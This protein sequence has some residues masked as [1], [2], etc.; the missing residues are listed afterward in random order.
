MERIDIVRR[1]LE[2][3]LRCRR[4]LRP[5]F[6]TVLIPQSSL[7][8]ASEVGVS[9]YKAG[10]NNFTAAIDHLIGF[11]RVHNSDTR[12][13]TVLN[14]HMRVVENL[15]ASIHRDDGRVFKESLHRKIV[16]VGLTPAN[17]A[18]SGRTV[19]RRFPVSFRH[20]AT[21][22]SFF[23]G[24]QSSRASLSSLSLPRASTRLSCEPCR[25]LP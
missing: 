22:R 14:Q 5:G 3:F 11:A 4:F 25:W 18:G 17:A 13:P 16:S 6:E 19:S 7:K 21:L 20:R 9:A 2:R 15:L 24:G 10:N 23:H 1:S 8:Q 12:N